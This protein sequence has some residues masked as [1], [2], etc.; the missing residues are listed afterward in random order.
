MQVVLATSFFCVRWKIL[1]T[2]G[3]SWDSLV[4]HFRWFKRL[5]ESVRTQSDFLK[6]HSDFFKNFLDFELDRIKNYSDALLS[7]TENGGMQPFVYFS[8]EFF[9][10]FVAQSKKYVIKFSYLSNS[11][12]CFFEVCCFSVY[13]FFNTASSSFSLKWTSLTSS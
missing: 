7:N 6:I 5:S 11:R 10:D 2:V 3:L 8:S 9:I 1:R 12:E 13:I 4:V